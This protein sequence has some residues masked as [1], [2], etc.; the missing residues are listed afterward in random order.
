M[1][2][3]APRRTLGRELHRRCTRPA[4]SP[5]FFRDRHHQDA[6]RSERGTGDGRTERVAW[7]TSGP[8][9][10]APPSRSGPAATSRL[11]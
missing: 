11:S 7:P 9:P 5:A 1:R 8:T 6:Q 4:A 2:L 3:G 10:T